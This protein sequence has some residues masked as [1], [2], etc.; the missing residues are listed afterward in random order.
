MAVLLVAWVG[1]T[2]LAWLRVETVG[3]RLEEI[4]AWRHDHHDGDLSDRALRAEDIE[5]RRRT[6]EA[7]EREVLTGRDGE[8]LS[9]RIE[10][11]S[12][13]IEEIERRIDRLEA[14]E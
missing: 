11:L 4:D 3:R 8:L 12:D 2:V 9:E 7:L 1:F 14:R 10:E 13:R 5:G 6:V